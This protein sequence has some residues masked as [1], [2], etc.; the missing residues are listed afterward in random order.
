MC[1]TFSFSY[2]YIPAPPSGTDKCVLLGCLVRFLGKQADSENH[3]IFEHIF[4]KGNYVDTF[5]QVANNGYVLCSF[6]FC[7]P[8]PNLCVQISPVGKHVAGFEA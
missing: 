3:L 5:F 4:L 2:I 1:L 6:Q 7:Q 8:L